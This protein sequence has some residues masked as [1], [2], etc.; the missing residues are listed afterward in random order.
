MNYSEQTILPDTSGLPL[1][2]LWSEALTGLAPVIGRISAPGLNVRET[3]AAL[4]EGAKEA[5]SRCETSA[6]SLYDAPYAPPDE[7][8]LKRISLPALAATAF[9]RLTGSDRDVHKRWLPPLLMAAVLGE[10]PHALLYHNNMHFRK[11]TLHAAR[12]M[13]AHKESLPAKDSALLLIAAC[14]H[15][16]GH[17]GS[18]NVGP[19]GAYTPGR[20]ERR[21]VEHAM[22]YLKAA[23]LDGQN[24][25][26]LETMIVCTDAARPDNPACP[27]TQ[28]R[29]SAAVHFGA[30][31]A[32][33]RPGAGGEIYNTLKARR[34][35]A[36]LALF[37]HEAD[38]MNSAGVSY[39]Q[40][41]LETTQ[42]KQES[43]GNRARPS[44]VLEFLGTICRGGF[45]SGAGRILGQNAYETIRA[46][47]QKDFEAGNAPY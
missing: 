24:L 20:L 12:L 41:R 42:F 46:R 19:D 6:Q 2:E 13:S 15:D 40:T 37:L 45:V 35:L 39:E 5:A 47:A 34:D 23:G 43:T 9:L 27:L 26:D 17:D 10:T 7:A 11:V 8:G 31:D 22:P 14:I 33:H 3:F 29:A 32:G 36:L 16:L 4:K 25:A 18:G 38:I 21:S 44:D 30:Q 1:Y 28:L